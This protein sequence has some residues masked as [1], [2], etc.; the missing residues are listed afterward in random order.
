MTAE[1]VNSLGSLEN[2]IEALRHKFDKH[3]YLRIDVKSGKQRSDLQNKAL[4]LYLSMLSQA[5]NDAGYDFRQTIKDDIEI[6]WSPELC[7]EYLWRVIQKAMTG[8]DS[9]TKPKTSDYP[10]IYETL[11][12]HTA[13]KLG[14]SVH[15]P[16]KDQ[17]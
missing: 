10:Q 8:A 4:H 16:C 3:G 5:L 13:Q 14:V 11:N 15:W 1:I 12:R 2:H 6:P 7:K 17:M 9:T